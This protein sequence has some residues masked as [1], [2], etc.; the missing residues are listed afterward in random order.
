MKDKLSKFSSFF[1]LFEKIRYLFILFIGLPMNWELS[2]A[3][4]EMKVSKSFDTLLLCII[5]C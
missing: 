1:V 4:E 3:A 2:K 5:V